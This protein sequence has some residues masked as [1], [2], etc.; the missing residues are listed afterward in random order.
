L[1]TN[2]DRFRDVFNG[3]TPYAGT[4]PKGFFVNWLGALTD[5]DFRAYEGLGRSNFG[6]AYVQTSLPRMAEGEGW[7]EA[8]NQVEAAREARGRFVM[9]TLGAC[10]GAQAVGS[11]LALRAI[12]PMPYKLVAVEPE[13]TNMEWVVRHLRDNGID[14]D[15]QWL[16]ET[17]LSDR[18]AP[19]LFPVGSPGSGAQNCFSTNEMGARQYYADELVASGRTE[20]ALRNLLLHNNT[21]VTKNL[22]PG[23]DFP[24]EIRMV[25]AVTLKHVLAP[26]DFIDYVEAD[27]QQSEILVFPPFMDLLKEKVRRVHIGT[28]GGE[29]HATLRDLFVEK[30]WEIIFD[31]APNSRFATSL[32]DFETNDGVLTVRNPDF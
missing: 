25:S 19:V 3:I 32:G 30:G 9:V 28:H 22:V 8:A 13:P 20:D 29:V 14:P 1:L 27:I 11:C 24:S 2:L 6:G 12:N 10:Y 23:Y 18:N 16:I 31:F 4:P 7:F 26:F 15:A 5:G 21:G 17:A